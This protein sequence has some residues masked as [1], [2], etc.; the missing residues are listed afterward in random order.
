MIGF[1]QLS[2]ATVGPIPDKL[3]LLLLPC[4]TEVDAGITAVEE[5]E[6]EADE[7]PSKIVSEHVTFTM[8]AAVSLVEDFSGCSDGR[9]LCNELSKVAPRA[10][11]LVGASERD[12][13]DMAAAC[14]RELAPHQTKVFTPGGI[15]IGSMLYNGC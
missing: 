11:V 5:D 14:R 6:L 15:E 9:S 1:A 10:L 3:M 8:Q 13:A 12:T 7:T 4:V 2:G